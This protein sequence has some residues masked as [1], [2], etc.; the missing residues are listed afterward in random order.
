MAAFHKGQPFCFGLVPKHPEMI[1]PGLPVQGGMGIKRR[2]AKDPLCKVPR[3]VQA[4]QRGQEEWD[5][6]A[7]QQRTPQVRTVRKSYEGGGVRAN[8]N[9]RFTWKA[10]VPDRN[11]EQLFDR[12]GLSATG[13]DAVCRTF[14]RIALLSAR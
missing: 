14:V 6:S 11:Q 5:R 1:A 2:T 3:P 9:R 4:R 12:P 13:E 10:P 8:K 7:A